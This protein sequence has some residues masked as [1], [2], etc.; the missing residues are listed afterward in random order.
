MNIFVMLNIETQHINLKGVSNL[1]L[2]L[3]KKINK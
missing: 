2:I 1:N 3:F